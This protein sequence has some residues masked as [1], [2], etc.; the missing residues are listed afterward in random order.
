MWE[1][2]VKFCGILRRMEIEVVNTNKPFVGLMG[3]N[4]LDVTFSLWRTC[5]LSVE[6]Q[7]KLNNMD[8]NNKVNSVSHSEL[9]SQNK[10]K[11]PRIVA[12]EIDTPI[13]GYTAEL[14]MKDRYSAIFH[15]Y[16]TVPYKIKESVSEEIDRMCRE[17]IF[18]PIKHSNWASSLVVQVKAN[19]TLRFCID[20]KVTV[21]KYLETDH[22]PLPRMYDIFASLSNCKVF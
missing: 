13:E 20:G 6:E 9:F 2:T 16:Y 18:R 7:E 19:N 14:V 4:W 12:T 11:F 1:V 3:R 5:F 17:N 8:R 10:S 15:C 21:N 22:Y